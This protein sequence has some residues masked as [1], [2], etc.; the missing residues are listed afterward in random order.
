MRATYGAEFDR[1]WECPVGVTPQAH[2]QNLMDTWGR[3]LAQLQQNPSAI[4]YGLDNLPPDRPPNLLQFKSICN[5]RPDRPL[6][7]LDAPRADPARVQQVI[8]GIRT[9][10]QE[11]DPLE[12]L[13]EL[14]ASDARDGTFRGRKVTLAQRQT[15][16]QALGMSKPSQETNP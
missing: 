11:R 9:P 10:R 13:R 12:T 5:R 3:A 15:Y 2:V 6:P 16:R 14:A 4:A 7:A 1:Q 8:A